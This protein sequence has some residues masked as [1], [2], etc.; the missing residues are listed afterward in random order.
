MTAQ[1]VSTVFAGLSGFCAVRMFAE[2]GTPEQPPRLVWY[3]INDDLTAALDAE[4][5]Y[6]ASRPGLAFYVIPGA[7]EENGASELH[8]RGFHSVCV[9]IDSAPVASKRATIV[10]ALGEPSLEVTSGGRTDAGEEKLHL[11][12][13]LVSPAPAADVAALRKMIADKAGADSSFGKPS[14]PIRVPG[15]RYGKGG[16]DRSGAVIGYCGATYSLAQLQ[17]AAQSMPV[18]PGKPAPD[19]GGEPIQLFMLRTFRP[20]AVDGTSRFEAVQRVAGHF[21]GKVRKGEMNPGQAE[22]A[23]LEWVRGHVEGQYSERKA[24]AALADFIER[25]GLLSPSNAPPSQDA[26]ARE[27]VKR[28]GDEILYCE[29]MGGWHMWTGSYWRRDVTNEAL[30]LTRRVVVDLADCVRENAN[31]YWRTAS[32]MTIAGVERIARS[33]RAIAAYAAQFDRDPLLLNTPGGVVDLRTGQLRAGRRD[34]YM[35]RVAGAVPGGECPRFLS[36]VSEVM[37]G[38]AELIRYLQTWIGY[39]LTGLNRES[40]VN[41]WYGGGANG[42]SVLLNVM[43]GICGTY[44][45][46]FNSNVLMASK[47]ERHPEEIARLRGVRCA[48]TS[49]VDQ[50]ARFDEAK[51]KL[52]SGGDRL[53]GRF[54][55]KDTFE[56]D[57]CFK[58]TIAGNHRPRI[59]NVDEAMR[60]RMHLVPFEVTVPPDRRDKMLGEKLKAEYPGI[61]AWAVQ[62]AVEYLRSGLHPPAR[63]IAATDDWFAAE[64]RLG[65]MIEDCFVRDPDAKTPTALL[66]SAYVGWTAQN[67][68]KFTMPQK[69]FTA[70]MHK[71]GFESVQVGQERTR[72]LKGLRLTFAEPLHGAPGG[73][74]T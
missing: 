18:G 60:R 64:D 43:A 15:S 41:F 37:G 54:M 14:Q 70:A 42:K 67:G 26:A 5:A 61:L 47:S 8:V 3:P 21:A 9:D 31:A 1:F 55:R 12:W 40:V 30:D 2:K 13:R 63:L 69:D 11:Y 27:L 39:N 20:D 58:I 29:E 44:A 50:N 56:F 48:I 33:D 4:A 36:F 19:V 17:Q 16:V 34:D 73:E 46:T 10:A 7:V 28:Y 53:T 68:E 38:D 51:F 22:A 24:A 6:A 66:Y 25:D 62:G 32:A 74:Q 65:R 57:P 52:M 23:L 45:M 72:S 71:R 35:T 59:T 49:E